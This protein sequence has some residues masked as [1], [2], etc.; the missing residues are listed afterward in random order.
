LNRPEKRDVFKEKQTELLEENHLEEKVELI[1]VSFAE[2]KKY[3]YSSCKVKQERSI[4][5]EYS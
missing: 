1:H 4:R 3:V 2:W 5:V